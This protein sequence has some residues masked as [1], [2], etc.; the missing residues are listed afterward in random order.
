MTVSLLDQEDKGRAA[1]HILS[2]IP[3]RK[4]ATIDIVEERTVLYNVT[5][6]LELP[7]AFSSARLVPEN[8]PLPMENGTVTIPEI[9]G[10]AIVELS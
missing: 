8:I 4:S 7:K 6:K 3:V 9:N 1:V 5:L 10:Y 2:Y